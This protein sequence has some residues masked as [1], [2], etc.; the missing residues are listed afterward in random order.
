M[1][2]QVLEVLSALCMYS[3][4][5]YSVVLEALQHYKLRSVVFT[6]F[7][8]FHLVNFPLFGVDLISCKNKMFTVLLFNFPGVQK[9]EI[10]IQYINA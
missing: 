10:Q 9:S 2:Q 3:E 5:G 6:K 8:E 4:H 1:K 7:N